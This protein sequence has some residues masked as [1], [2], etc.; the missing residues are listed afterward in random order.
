M[1]RRNL[2]LVAALVPLL[3]TVACD[4]EQD[5]IV[6]PEEVEERMAIGQ[7]S[8]IKPYHGL[9]TGPMT[10]VDGI[11]QNDYDATIMLAPGLCTVSG[12][13]LFRAQWDYYNHGVTCTSELDLLGQ[14]IDVNGLR[15]WTFYD[16]NLTGPCTDGY[17]D[18]TETNDPTVMDHQWRSLDGVVDAA[19]QLDRNGVCGSIGNP[20]S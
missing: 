1:T 6:P 15:T 7:I 3:A 13:D 12:D 10:Q 11:A 17:V 2:R 5:A 14:S 9:W 16:A 20:D 8:I 19:G 18:L 4:V